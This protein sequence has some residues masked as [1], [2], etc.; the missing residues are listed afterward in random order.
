MPRSVLLMMR[1]PYWNKCWL[2]PRHALST[3]PC[4]MPGLACRPGQPNL[5]GFPLATAR[6]PTRLCKPSLTSSGFE[7]AKICW[8]GQQPE[9]EA[10]VRTRERP[11]VRQVDQRGPERDRKLHQGRDPRVE[12]EDQGQAAEGLERHGVVGGTP[13][14]AL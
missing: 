10:P 3:T 12:A 9:R 7:S 8:S 2:Q 6:R 13:R 11:A 14:R 5:H 4:T 1:Q